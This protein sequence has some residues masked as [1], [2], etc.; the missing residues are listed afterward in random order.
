MLRQIVRQITEQNGQT[1]AVFTKSPLVFKV[2]LLK[3]GGKS[4]FGKVTFK[5]LFTKPPLWFPNQRR[6]LVNDPLLKECIQSSDW[7][8]KF[9]HKG[10]FIFPLLLYFFSILSIQYET[11]V[12]ICFILPFNVIFYILRNEYLLD[13]CIAYHIVVIATFQTFKMTHIYTHIKHIF[14][15]FVDISA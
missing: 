7:L 4:L 1:G 11:R 13:F 9:I 5:I 8:K 10:S 3:E 15:G 14:I 2:P 12:I 6:P